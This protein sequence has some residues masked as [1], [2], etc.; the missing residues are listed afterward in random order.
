MRTFKYTIILNCFVVLSFTTP[1]LLAQTKVQASTVQNLGK[2]VSGKFYFM[3]SMDTGLQFFI[4]PDKQSKATIP[5]LKGHSSI[6]ISNV[7]Q[8]SKLTGIPEPESDPGKKYWCLS[9]SG[10]ATIFIDD[11]KVRTIEDE[12]GAMQQL[13]ATA[14]S[15]QSAKVADKE[16][17]SE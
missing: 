13:F 7:K 16:C 1:F 9:Y 11:F 4:E 6:A 3:N 17:L 10:Q 8:M 5:Q 2:K 15:V 14:R 12:E